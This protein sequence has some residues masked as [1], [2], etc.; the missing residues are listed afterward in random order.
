MVGKLCLKKYGDKFDV[1]L[2]VVLIVNVVDN[3]GDFCGN[4]DFE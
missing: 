3:F 2:K 1:D 4:N